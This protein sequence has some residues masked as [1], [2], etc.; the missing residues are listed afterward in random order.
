MLLELPQPLTWVEQFTASEL[1]G[2]SSPDRYINLVSKSVVWCPTEPVRAWL[3]EQGMRPDYVVISYSKHW[4]VLALRFEN[5]D[6]AFAF[7]MRWL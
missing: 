3:Y 6:D 7:R 5:P 4:K 1:F 2:P